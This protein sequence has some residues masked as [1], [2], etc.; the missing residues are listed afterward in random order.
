MKSEIPEKIKEWAFWLSSEILGDS[1]ITICPWAK[2]SIIEGSVDY[3]ENVNPLDLIPLPPKIKVRIVGFPEHSHEK[4]IEIIKKCNDLNEEFIFLESHPDDNEVIGSIKSVSEVPLI[5]IQRR[6]E[7]E[8]ARKILKKT[9]YYNFWDP[10][11]LKK[12]L[13]I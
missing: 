2:K 4:L 3:M 7:L 11:I 6:S 8:N 12:I 10:Y 1:K 5:L 13:S 9:E